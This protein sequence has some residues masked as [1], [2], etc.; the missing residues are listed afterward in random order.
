MTSCLNISVYEVPETV[1]K[2]VGLF[3]SH[4]YVSCVGSFMGVFSQIWVSFMGHFSHIQGS[5][6]TCGTPIVK[7]VSFI[8]LFL[9]IQVSFH[10]RWCVHYVW[11]FDFLCP[12]CRSQF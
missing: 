4:S 12:S 2:S 5:F 9:H 10:K 7:Y 6:H 3:Q 11:L 8:G 1:S